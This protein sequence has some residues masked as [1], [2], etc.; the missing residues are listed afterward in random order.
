MLNKLF[1]K[2][3]EAKFDFDVKFHHD[4]NGLP[5]HGT[6]YADHVQKNQKNAPIRFTFGDIPKIPNLTPDLLAYIFEKAADQGYVVH[7]LRSYA[8]IFTVQP[9]PRLDHFQGANADGR[10]PRQGISRSLR[11]P[12]GARAE[13]V[14]ASAG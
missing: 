5:E 6:I 14:A 3:K 11:R 4:A 7:C 12:S 9:G 8:N 10:P 13:Q 2:N 1:G